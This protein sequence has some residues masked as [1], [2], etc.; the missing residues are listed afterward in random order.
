VYV[1]MT[2]MFVSLSSFVISCSL[3]RAAWLLS[4]QSDDVT[5]VHTAANCSHLMGFLPVLSLKKGQSKYFVGAME[6]AVRRANAEYTACRLTYQTH[7][8]NADTLVSLRAMTQL[9]TDGAIAFIGPEDTCATEA[10]LAAAWNLP[11]IAFVSILC[12]IYHYTVQV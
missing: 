5:A 8:N 7:D 3:F 9:H 1:T 10:R 11:M 6:Y 4:L 2:P 12:V